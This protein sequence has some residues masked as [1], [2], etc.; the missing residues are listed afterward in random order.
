MT[1]IYAMQR[2]N[3]DW[4]V[5]ERDGRLNVPV[6]PTTH[7]ALMS[8]FRNLGMLLFKPVFL[9]SDLLQQLISK[10]DGKPIDFC[11][12]DDPFGSLFRGKRLGREQLEVLMKGDAEMKV[13][14]A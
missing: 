3:G 1:G 4:F 5:E 7:F 13:E 14:S 2:A 12:I 10:A 11:L 9:N 8:R 6:F